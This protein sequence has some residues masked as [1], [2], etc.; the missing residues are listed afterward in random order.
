MQAGLVSTR[1]N[2]SDIFTAHGLSLRIFVTVVRIPVPVQLKETGVAELPTPSQRAQALIELAV[3]LQSARRG[4]PILA[5]AQDR[6]TVLLTSGEEPLLVGMLKDADTDA[7]RNFRAMMQRGVDDKIDIL[8]TD[9]VLENSPEL[10]ATDAKPFWKD[11]VI[12]TTRSALEGRQ[13]ELRVLRDV[14]LPENAEALARAADYGDL[15]ENAEW[16]QAIEQQRML[17]EKAKSIEIELGKAALLENAIMLE[18]TVC[19]GMTVAYLETDTGQER[20]MT[21][22]GPWDDREDAVSYRAPLAQG[23]LGLHTGERST[24]QL[25]SGTVDVEIQTITPAELT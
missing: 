22:L 1:M 12:W 14:K 13:E 15:S 19:P 20:S 17:T 24:V 21:L 5:R 2:W 11:D 23:M 4:N 10:F 6:L 9:I 25:P 8:V 3:Y 16:E 7:L 18:D